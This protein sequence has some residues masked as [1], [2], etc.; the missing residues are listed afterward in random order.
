[1]DNEEYS[2]RGF[3]LSLP[4]RQLM[5]KRVMNNAIKT[6][7]EITLLHHLNA[8]YESFGRIYI[9]DSKPTMEVSILL[10]QSF[11]IIDLT[12][13]KERQTTYYYPINNSTNINLT[14]FYPTGELNTNDNVEFDGD[15]PY[16]AQLEI[17]N[18]MVSLTYSAEGDRKTVNSLVS[19]GHKCIAF[20]QRVTAEGGRR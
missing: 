13:D 16:R 18:G 5:E 14:V 11:G 6:L 4:Q 10:P 17:T 1:M 9:K 15:L 8:G 20:L 3:I 2:I 12:F 19:Y 7:E